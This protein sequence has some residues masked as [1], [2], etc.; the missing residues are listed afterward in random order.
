MDGPR[1]EDDE[2]ETRRL[3]KQKLVAKKWESEMKVLQRMRR[4]RVKKPI[5]KENI[6]N[7]SKISA[8]DTQSLKSK[9]ALETVRR[10]NSYSVHSKESTK[11]EKDK[12]KALSSSLPA[13][14]L[15]DF[16]KTSSGNIPIDI[17]K[18]NVTNEKVSHTTTSNNDV[19]LNTPS[20]KVDS[21]AVPTKRV[22]DDHDLKS[23][24]IQSFQESDCIKLADVE[25]PSEVFYSSFFQNSI[26]S[27][28]ANDPSVYS[29]SQKRLRLESYDFS[30]RLMIDETQPDM[31]S[32]F[33]F[34]YSSPKLTK[35]LIY[36]HKPPTL[37]EAALPNK[38][39]DYKVPHYS[40]E[41]DLPKYP[42]VFAGKEF[43]L[44]TCGIS[45]LK[46][47]QSSFFSKVAERKNLQ[48][49]TKIKNWTPTIR[50]PKYKEV[51][52]WGKAN[53][54]QKKRIKNSSTQVRNK[55]NHLIRKRKL[56]YFT[57]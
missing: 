3:K 1:D 48:P 43:K 53:K 9:P 40:R 33:E 51:D 15:D 41:A 19:L 21:S 4:A 55:S 54:T 20:T 6:E 23:N 44:P 45:F 11:S 25:M 56:I 29:Q 27:S 30:Q 49:F 36:R 35:E 52:E 42:T 22:V 18:T 13:S 39:L 46:E 14:S 38:G 17:K 10:V 2:E 50:P 24:D 12:T 57:F 47:F 16:S 7:S 32:Q 31:R 8:N 28:A 5:T 37:S 26:H 34:T